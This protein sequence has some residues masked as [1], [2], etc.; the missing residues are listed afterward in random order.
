M[1]Q[2]YLQS[3]IKELVDECIDIE[4]LYIVYS[5]LGGN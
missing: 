1:E 3:H 4:L 2:K 5:L